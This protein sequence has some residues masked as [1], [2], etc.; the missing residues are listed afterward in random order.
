[1][2]VDD[3]YSFDGLSDDQFLGI[4]QTGFCDA[5]HIEAFVYEGLK[6]GIAS[7]H[8]GNAFDQFIEECLLDVGKRYTEL[9]TA[10][11]F[12]SDIDAYHSFVMDATSWLRNGKALTA[13]LPER[14]DSD[15]ATPDWPWPIT[16]PAE[17]MGDRS[18]EARHYQD[19]SG[20]WMCGYRVG[21]SGLSPLDRT[22]L[23]NYFFRNT[24]PR[25]VERHF[26]NQYGDPGS[27][28][29]LRRMASV[30]ARNCRTFKRLSRARFAEAIEAWEKDLAYL[31]RAYY[32]AGMFP[33]PPIE[34]EHKEGEP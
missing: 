6:R 25:V 30:I 15:D 11:G 17:P 8:L 22:R 32:R 20:L 31:K 3:P 5:R 14:D 16:E 29:R 24:L 4:I 18:T 23:L 10:L 13:G 28:Q 7:D 21:V 34:G 9:F 26:G 2:P 27:E 1:M 19:N 12:N 33:W